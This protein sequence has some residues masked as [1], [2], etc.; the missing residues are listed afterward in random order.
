MACQKIVADL[1]IALVRINRSIYTPAQCPSA[2]PKS[3]RTAVQKDHE[4][5]RDSI[6]RVFS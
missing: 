5:V 3:H 4:S 2:T 1:I 6:A